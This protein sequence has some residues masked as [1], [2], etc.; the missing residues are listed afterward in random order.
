MRLGSTGHEVFVVQ[1]RLAS[2]GFNPGRPD[3]DFGPATEAAVLAFQRSEGLLADGI[4]GPRTA[5]KLNF[6]AGMRSITNQRV[7]AVPDRPELSPALVAAM[8]PAAPIGN[9]N[10]FLPAVAQ[11]LRDAALDTLPVVLGAL[12]TIR[13]ETASFKPVSEGISRYNTSPGGHDFDLYDHRRDLGNNN[14]FDGRAFMGRGFI[15][16]TGRANYAK[17]GP[18]VGVPDLV[19]LPDKANDPAIAARLLAAFIS[20]VEVPFKE[21]LLA[22]DLPRARRLVNGGTH[23]LAAFESAYRAGQRKLGVR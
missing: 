4:I 12:A 17:F 5:A 3:G 19:N 18:L 22:E 11:A 14:R 23:G 8:F 2:L 1:E 7:F 21:A 9:I 16:L 15:Q 10:R 13:A 6:D 20:A